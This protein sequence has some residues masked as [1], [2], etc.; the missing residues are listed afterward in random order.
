MAKTQIDEGVLKYVIKF[1]FRGIEKKLLKD[2][3]IRKD[4]RDISKNA[5][6]INAAL[7]RVEKRTGKDLSHLKFKLK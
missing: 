1:F 7:Q 5:A 2:P 3:K 4:L 6:S